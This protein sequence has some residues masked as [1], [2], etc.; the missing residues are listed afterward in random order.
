MPAI[1][2]LRNPDNHERTRRACLAV[3]GQ[4]IASS[5]SFS[6]VSGPR[7]LIRLREKYTVQGYLV[8]FIFNSF[9]NTCHLPFGTIRGKGG[10]KGTSWVG[11]RCVVEYI[12]ISGRA[13]QTTNER[14]RLGLYSTK[15]ALRYDT[16]LYDMTRHRTRHDTI[17][18]DTT[19]NKVLRWIST[20]LSCCVSLSLCITWR[21]CGYIYRGEWGKAPSSRRGR[22]S[23]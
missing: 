2:E 18:H 1:L 21:H 19:R 4:A 9:L 15:Y 10:G 17:R 8:S 12:Y 23:C 22:K 11:A 7:E 3:E 5:S 13:T 14:I 20:P 6:H 16:I